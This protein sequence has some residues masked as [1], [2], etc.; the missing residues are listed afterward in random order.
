[1]SIAA[2]IEAPV[3]RPAGPDRKPSAITTATARTPTRS[4]AGTTRL[5]ISPPLPSDQ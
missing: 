1:V 4:A 3:G 2:P 5:D